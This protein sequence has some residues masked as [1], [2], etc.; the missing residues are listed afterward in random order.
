MQL[1]EKEKDIG[2]AYVM[3][4]AL[5]WNIFFYTPGKQHTWLDSTWFHLSQISWS[6]VQ[7]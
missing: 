4:W 6:G 3:H 5:L 7:Y 2:E 1:L